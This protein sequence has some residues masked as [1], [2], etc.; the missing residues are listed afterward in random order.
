MTTAERADAVARACHPLNLAW[1]PSCQQLLG[2]VEAELG[3]AEALDRFV[4]HGEVSSR[5]ASLTPIVHILA[6]NTPDAAIQTLT[7]GLLIGAHNQIKLPAG[8]IAEV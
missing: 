3:H 1:T 7:R 2:L 8:G 6:S 4:P 5:A